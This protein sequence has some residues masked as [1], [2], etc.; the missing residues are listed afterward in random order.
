MPVDFARNRPK[1][2][3]LLMTIEWSLFVPGVLLL[4]LPAD[5]FLSAQVELRG[6]ESFRT[7]EDSPRHRPW[8]WVPMLWLDPLRSYAGALL[9][10]HALAIG[11]EKWEFMSKPAYA[12]LVALLGLAVIVQGFTRRDREML[13]A[14][15][16]FVA[17]LAA[18]LLPWTVALPGVVLAAVALFGLRHFQAFFGV[19]AAVFASLGP[20]LR[21]EAAWFVPAASA[22]V[23]PI[24]VA[25]LAGRTLAVPTRRAEQATR[26]THSLS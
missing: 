14:P 4:L 24:I 16:G 8:W 15:L 13:L 25:F 20:A 6:F 21:V 2:E 26:P 3:G 19:G 5:L 10:Q 22:F 18:A 23:V 12:L 17:G 7:L 1:L 11:T 9:I